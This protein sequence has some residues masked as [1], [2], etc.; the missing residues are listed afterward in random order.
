MERGLTANKRIG[1]RGS[2]GGREREREES[3]SVF[4]SADLMHAFKKIKQ[5]PKGLCLGR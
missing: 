2:E 5:I 1:A 3:P 4:C